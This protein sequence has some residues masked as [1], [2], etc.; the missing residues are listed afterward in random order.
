M[1]HVAASATPDTRFWI[2]VTVILAMAVALLGAG[3]ATLK[4]R[5]P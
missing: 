1:N 4:R 3:A 2:D 5:T